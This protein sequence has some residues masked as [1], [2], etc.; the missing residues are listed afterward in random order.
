MGEHLCQAYHRDFSVTGVILRLFNVYGPGQRGDFLIPSII[1]QARTG[2]VLL[3]DAA[4]ERDFVYVDDVIDACIMAGRSDSG[5][6]EVINIG[7]GESHSVEAVVREV[8]KCFGGGL[9]ANYT[10]EKRPNE[11]PVTVAD[12]R[13]ARKLLGWEPKVGFEQGIRRCVDW[14]R[15]EM[16]EQTFDSATHR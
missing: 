14:G 16:A 1:N 5:N 2:R 12:I 4:P 10:G 7:T 15:D 13:K 11:I 3:K 9:K 6:M 8:T